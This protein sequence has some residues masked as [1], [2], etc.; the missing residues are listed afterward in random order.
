LNHDDIDIKE[1]VGEWELGSQFTCD[2][3]F[4]ALYFDTANRIW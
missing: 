1:Q 3:Y 4:V 2:F